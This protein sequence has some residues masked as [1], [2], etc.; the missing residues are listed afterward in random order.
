MP[1]ILHFGI[2]NFHRAHQAWYTAEANRV[3]GENWSITGVSLRSASIR[4]QL[5]PQQFSYT[6]VTKGTVATDYQTISVHDDILVGAQHCEAIIDAVADPDTSC[7][8]LTVTE[9][10]YSLDPSTGEIVLDDS[11]LQSELA[12]SAPQTIYAFL[13]K[14][15]QRRAE[16][17]GP[18]LNIISCDNLPDNGRKLEQAVAKYCE[19]AGIFITGFLSDRV[20]FANTMVDRIVPAT[21]DALCAEVLAETGQR[22]A[23]PVSTEAFTQWYVE[24]RLFDP[25]PS[26]KEAGA[27][28]VEDVAPFELRKLRL[29]NGSHSLL[30][31]AGLLAGHEFV[32]QA[33]KDAAIRHKVEGFMSE[34]ATTLPAGIRDTAVDYRE[35]LFDRFANPHLNHRLEQIAMDGSQKLPVRIVPVIRELKAL[36]AEA[37]FALEAVAIWAKFVVS[38]IRSDIRL[39]DPRAAE[40]AEMM[41]GTGDDQAMMR[42]LAAE[43]FE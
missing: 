4:E 38:R 20:A 42:W 2:G 15:L 32:H 29:L 19:A 35:A 37:S 16:Q 39:D 24:D 28:F 22:D 12:G 1:C 7:I 31:Y 33:V 40:F 8:T 18:P 13:A 27:T 43:V 23:L 26:W 17:D 41:H 34:A 25:Y 9:K 21:T 36:G 30:A 10:G 11:V 5:E 3:S 14:G 6:L